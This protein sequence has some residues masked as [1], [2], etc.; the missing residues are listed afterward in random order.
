LLNQKVSGLSDTQAPVPRITSG[1]RSG[2]DFPAVPEKEVKNM[3]TTADL[4][5]V[6]ALVLI[7]V[8]SFFGIRWILRA[9]SKYGGTQIVTCP[10]TNTSA[11]VEVDVLEAALTSVLGA[12][13]I[14]LQNCSRWPTKK[15]CGQECLLNLTVA[16]SDCL[17]HGVLMKWYR[18]KQC[19]YCGMTFTELHLTDHKPA[20]RNQAGKLLQ[21]NE[22]AIA[23][24]P[25]V[26]RSYEPVCWNCYIAQSFAIEHPELVTY[27][28]WKDEA[29]TR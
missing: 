27:R 8:A 20:L 15:D 13:D 12:S 2:D 28:P 22:V 10:E 11:Y 3:D 7:A 14:R 17:V 23:D 19:L 4:L 29:L 9:R 16:P 1:S 26:L 6:T 18:G 25:K 5:I 21:W 24:M